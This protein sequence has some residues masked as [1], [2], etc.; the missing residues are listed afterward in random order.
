VQEGE[1]GANLHFSDV[2]SDE[3]FEPPSTVT[4]RSGLRTWLFGAGHGA[5]NTSGASIPDGLMAELQPN[6]WSG[7]LPRRIKLI[8]IKFCRDTKPE[9]TL[10]AMQQQHEDLLAACKRLRRR[11]TKAADEPQLTR[12]ILGACGTI[13]EEH[14]IS[15]LQSLGVKGT[16]LDRLLTDLRRH[17]VRS[18]HAI[19]VACYAGTA[20]LGTS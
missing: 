5:V 10:E 16:Q 17:A 18:L 6:R 11:K 13:F 7:P 12:I 3:N 1:Q 9:Q 15:A 14:T 20:G 4:K 2:G 19:A 8:E